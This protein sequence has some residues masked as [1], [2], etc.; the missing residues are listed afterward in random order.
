MLQKRFGQ[1]SETEVEDRGSGIATGAAVE[2]A[3]SITS[4]PLL[5]PKDEKKEEEKISLF[6]RV[7]GGTILSIVA[8]VS[9][10]LF[11]NLQSS[12]SDLRGELSREREA[13]AGLA[14]KDDVDARIKTQYERIRVVEGY[15][16][17]IEAIKERA[18]ANAMGAETIR[19]DMSASLDAIK[20]ETAG[21]EVLKE[22]I[23]LLETLK[24][25]VAA[26]DALKEKLA[27]A[28][29]E[30]KTVRED[31]AKASQEVEKNKAADLERKNSRDAQTKMFEETI[32]ELQK[33][34]QA[35]REKIARLEGSQ[36]A[37]P[38]KKKADEKP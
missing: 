6:W 5:S 8:L 23:A 15:K 25:D 20:K 27:A 11:N 38:E 3:R 22:R 17:E 4:L 29:T 34:V 31:I 33:D 30:L 16:A 14:K 13:R 9:I 28:N 24:K 35:C 19:K 10:T 18:S 7:F 21:I 37:N 32:K 26:L 2:T 1:E 36:P 12:I